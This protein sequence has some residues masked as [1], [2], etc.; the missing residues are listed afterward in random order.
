MQN[1]IT[2][3]SMVK[4][5]LWGAGVY[6]VKSKQICYSWNTGR[7]LVWPNSTKGKQGKKESYSGTTSSTTSK[8]TIRSLNFKS[9]EKSLRVLRAKWHNLIW[10]LKCHSQC[11]GREEGGGKYRIRV[12]GE[13]NIK[14]S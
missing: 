5:G 3:A 14:V 10:V 2:L 6:R 11:C 12:T 1:K 4:D 7:S 13:N 9:N 8:T